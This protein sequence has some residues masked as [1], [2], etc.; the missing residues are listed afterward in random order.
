MLGGRLLPP[1]QQRELLTTVS[2][3]GSNW[4]PDTRYGLGIFTQALPGG[5]TVWGNGGATYGSWTYAMGSQDGTHMLTSNINGDW[6][7]LGPFTDLLTAEF[8]PA[9]PSSD[10]PG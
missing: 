10:T 4:I 8:D 9:Q 7:S 3:D 6:S 2:T 1:A 5:V